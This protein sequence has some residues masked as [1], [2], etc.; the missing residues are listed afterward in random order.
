[1]PQFLDSFLS[2]ALSRVD[3]YLWRVRLACNPVSH[4]RTARLLSK[5]DFTVVFFL[6]TILTLSP[7]RVIRH[8]RRVSR[9]T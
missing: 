3:S 7:L 4:P 2:F 8:M 5:L 1:V 6:V 9:S